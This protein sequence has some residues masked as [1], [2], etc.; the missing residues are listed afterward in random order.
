LNKLFPCLLLGI[1]VSACHQGQRQIVSNSFID[2]LIQQYAPPA[3]ARDN[4]AEMRFWKGRINPALPDYLNQSRYAGGL[5]TEFRLFGEIDSLRKSDSILTKVLRDFNYKEAS[6]DFALTAHCI[7]EHQFARADSFLQKA[8]ELGLRPYESSSGSFDVDFERGAYSQAQLEL[9]AIRSDNDF[10]YFFRKSKMDHLKGALDSSIADMLKSARLAT[11]SD[12]LKGVAL[13]NAGDLYIHAGDLESAAGLYRQ[14]VG[15]NSA[16]FHSWMGLGWIAAIHDHNDT[17]AEKIFRFVESKN[18]LPDPLFKL[19]ELAQT[20]GDSATQKKAALAFVQVATDPRYGR[21]YNKYLLQF[22]TG[23]LHDANRAEALTKDELTNRATP[24]TY[25]WY[26]WALFANRKTDAAY[27]IFDQ[28]V[29][30]KPLE[31]LEL[32]YMG[33]M[34]K[35]LG[36]GYNAEQF[37]KAANTTR[38]DLGPAIQQDI[39]KQL[40]D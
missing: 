20:A 38:Y 28:Y 16:D 33:K 14:C 19:A 40:A 29:S 12:Y 30:G 17:L 37:F 34:M 8:K 1:L 5:A 9:N 22:Y 7:T 39:Q 18:K 3:I 21:M 31:G 11:N 35:G 6:A 4:E 23:I 24:Q 15:L 25:A 27:R 2:S 10:G 26:A 13:A 32:Y 36:K